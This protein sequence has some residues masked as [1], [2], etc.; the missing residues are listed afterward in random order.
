MKHLY[1]CAETERVGSVY[2]SLLTFARK[3]L[4]ET[5]NH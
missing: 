3:D 1:E 2:R 4:I 5:S